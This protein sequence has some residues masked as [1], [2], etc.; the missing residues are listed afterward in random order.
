MVQLTKQSAG[1]IPKGTQ[2]GFTLL[3]VLGA[4]TLNNRSRYAISPPEPDSLEAILASAGWSSTFVD[5]SDPAAPADS[6][7]R[8]PLRARDWGT[9]PM[10]LTPS[11]A[12]D[13]LIYID[14]VTPPEYL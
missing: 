2:G 5:L 4:A 12:F 7:R 6:W 14:T 9:T 8:M 13:G 10:T 1:R 3:E 11:R